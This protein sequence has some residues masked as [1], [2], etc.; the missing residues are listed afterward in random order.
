MSAQDETQTSNELY[1]IDTLNIIKLKSK[2]TKLNQIQGGNL[3]ILW[4]IIRCKLVSWVP[5][6]TKRRRR[7]TSSDLQAFQST[8]DDGEDK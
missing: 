2:P 3:H 4:R 5:I 6:Y 7:G 8:D 1:I